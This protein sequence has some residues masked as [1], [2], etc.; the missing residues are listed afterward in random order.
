MMHQDGIIT[1][2]T[3][4]KSRGLVGSQCFEHPSNHQAKLGSAKRKDNHL[5]M[6]LELFIF[7]NTVCKIQKDSLLNLTVNQEL[8]I[9]TLLLL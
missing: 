3:Q 9:L 5:T 4:Q 1:L 7:Y 8:S 6:A 2:L